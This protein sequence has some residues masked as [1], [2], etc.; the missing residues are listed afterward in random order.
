MACA[1]MELTILAEKWSN[2]KKRVQLINHFIFSTI[3]PARNDFCGLVLFSD[4]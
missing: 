2:K 1:S 3:I 4:K